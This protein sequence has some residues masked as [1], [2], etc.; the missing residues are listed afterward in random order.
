MIELFNTILVLLKG[1]KKMLPHD[2]AAFIDII[3]RH[4]ETAREKAHKM[5]QETNSLEKQTVHAD[6]EIGD[7]NG[8]IKDKDEVIVDLDNQLYERNQDLMGFHYRC[9]N[10]LAALDKANEKLADRAEPTEEPKCWEDTRKAK[11]HF[12]GEV[13]MEEPKFDAKL[14]FYGIVPMGK[15]FRLLRAFRSVVDM[16]YHAARK[17]LE[18]CDKTAD[19]VAFD[20]FGDIQITVQQARELVDE[21]NAVDQ[22]VIPAVNIQTN[23]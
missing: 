16:E 4:V 19:F 12:D 2:S 22:R 18:A 7:L 8:V 20:K 1:L 15:F 13:A 10:L 9:K 3:L 14:Q 5:V 17:L 23:I 11:N 6:K 21:L